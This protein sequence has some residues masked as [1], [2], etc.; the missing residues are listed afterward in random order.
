MLEMF[1][2]RRIG[3]PSEFRREKR[4]VSRKK[5]SGLYATPQ[6]HNA[7]CDQRRGEGGEVHN[8]QDIMRSAVYNWV[9]GGSAQRR[10][11]RETR[12]GKV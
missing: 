1:L 3:V 11:D 6:R 12:E 2:E 8:L 10:F 9:C 4:I 5:L 7:I